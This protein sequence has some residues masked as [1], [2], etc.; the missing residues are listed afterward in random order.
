MNLH[1]VRGSDGA[2]RRAF[3][4]DDV[5]RMLKAGI[6]KEDE[7][8]E[9]IEGE[10]VV[11]NAGGFAHDRLKMMLGRRFSRVLPDELAVGIETSV[12]LTPRSIVQPD[13]VVG[14]DRGVARTKEGF[15]TIPAAEV[16]LIIEIASSS[17]SFDRGRKAQ[18]YA[19]EGI[20]EYWVIDANR[21]RTWVHRDPEPQ[22]YRTV[23]QVTSGQTLRPASPALAAF[24]ASLDD[25]A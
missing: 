4:A 23:T 10:L 25:L 5:R 16:M 1:L 19:R 17:L 18:L 13:I 2:E 21:R 9:L 8:F 20:A 24:S 12:Q 22:G 3:T 14:P 6:L 7:R 15:L 11:M